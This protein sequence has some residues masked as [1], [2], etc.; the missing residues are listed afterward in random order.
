MT[1]LKL[2]ELRAEA[3][4]ELTRLTSAVIDDTTLFPAW[5]KVSDR[6]TAIESK[7]VSL[8]P[9]TLGGVMA[10]IEVLRAYKLDA[11][12][13]KLAMDSGLHKSLSCAVKQIRKTSAAVATS[14]T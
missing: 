13:R 7:I 9:E 5:V 1:I 8:A 6:L 2:M 4:A 14:L 10:K 11:L 3:Q 12:A